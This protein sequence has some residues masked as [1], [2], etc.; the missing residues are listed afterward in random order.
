MILPESK[1]GNRARQSRCRFLCFLLF[2]T[3]HV[4]PL[5]KILTDD[6]A[7]RPTVLLPVGREMGHRGRPGSQFSSF[8]V[9][10]DAACVDEFMFKGL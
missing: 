3:R 6:E 5:T 2:K 9:Q 4:L 1:E 8:G 7:R 10:L